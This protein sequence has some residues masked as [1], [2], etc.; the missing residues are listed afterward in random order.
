MPE[1]S[2]TAWITRA[3]PLPLANLDTDQ[4]MPKQFLRGIDKA[5]LA[6]G[7]L[8]D[9]RFDAHGQP[10]PECVLNQPAFADVDALIGGP[11]FGCGSS[12]EHAVWGLL[13]YGVRAVIAP[14]F[15]E[16]FYSNAVNNRLLPVMVS[17]AHGQA[18]LDQA[19]ACAV[20]GE[21]PLPLQI[22]L[23]ALQ[24]RCGTIEAPFA[25]SPRHQRM[26]LQGLD[27]VGATLA[28]A[29]QIEA[30][31]ARHFAAQPWLQDRAMLTQERLTAA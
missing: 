18:L 21:G 27:M 1:T 12:R 8:Y 10:R 13:Q 14:S 2:T 28:H 4:I 3:A 24:V 23:P 26:L 17:P 25:L 31:A 5:G 19:L 29:T 7:L 22:D 15:G 20:A 30:F 16:I 11:N 9:L 6:R